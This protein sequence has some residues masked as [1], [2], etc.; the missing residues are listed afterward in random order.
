MKRRNNAKKPNKQQQQPQAQHVGDDA[1]ANAEED[2]AVV[3]DPHDGDGV[4][5][6]GTTTPKGTPDSLRGDHDARSANSPIILPAE[7]DNGDADDVDGEDRD[8]DAGTNK[9]K[10]KS[11]NKKRSV[12]N[13]GS[14]KVVG[15]TIADSEVASSVSP[16]VEVSSSSSLPTS[17]TASSPI[18]A[19][20]NTNTNT[21]ANAN[22]S[23]STTTTTT[24]T[25]CT[26]F[27]KLDS[28]DLLL[29]DVLKPSDVIHVRLENSSKWSCSST[30]G[31]EVKCVEAMTEFVILYGLSPG[32]IKLSWNK[33]WSHFLGFEAHKEDSP[34]FVHDAEFLTASSDLIPIVHSTPSKGELIVSLGSAKF[35]GT[36]ISSTILDR[37][38]LDVTNNIINAAH[39]RLS[40]SVSHFKDLEGANSLYKNMLEWITPTLTTSHIPPESSRLL[41]TLEHLPL[42]RLFLPL[43]HYLGDSIP[44]YLHMERVEQEQLFTQALEFMDLHPGLSFLH[45]GLAQGRIPVIVCAL[46]GGQLNYTAWN[47]D[48]ALEKLIKYH[49]GQISPHYGPQNV[50]VDLQNCFMFEPTSETQFDRVLICGKAPQARFHQMCKLIKPGGLL[51][52]CFETASKAKLVLV[53]KAIDGSISRAALPCPLDL[54]PSSAVV[55]LVAPPM[56]SEVKARF[57]RVKGDF[58]DEEELKQWLL[59]ISDA[60]G[61]ELPDYSTKILAAGFSLSV[62]KEVGLA[63]EDVGCLG[64]PQSHCSALKFA[65]DKYVEFQKALRDDTKVSSQEMIVKPTRV[66]ITFTRV[67]VVESEFDADVDI[68]LTW[69]DEIAWR[70]FAAEK[71]LN[72][73]TS[74]QAEPVHIALSQLHPIPLLGFPNSKGD[75]TLTSEAAYVVPHTGMIEYHVSFSGTFTEIM[76]LQKFPFDRQLLHLNLQHDTRKQ[77]DLRVIWDLKDLLEES[78][79]P[80]NEKENNKILELVS[81]DREWA[82]AEA[83][84]DKEPP[85]A[86]EPREIEQL[87]LVAQAER[88]SSYFMWNIVFMM[89]LIVVMSFLTFTIPA[90]DGSGRLGLNLTLMLTAV[91][92]KYVIAG[93]LPKTTYLTLLDKYVLVGFIVLASVICENSAASV[94]EDSAAPFFDKVAILTLIPLWLLL[95][96]GIVIGCAFD[97]FRQSWA[98][99]EASQETTEPISGPVYKADSTIPPVAVSLIAA[100]AVKKGAR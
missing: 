23:T 82:R 38:V 94:A 45:I 22:A 72:A 35:P 41:H 52:G 80:R 4:V 2:L 47:I 86:E 44:F 81:A 89:F 28:N 20:A 70:E 17:L 88:Y 69:K 57:S 75:V 93:Y 13:K 15:Q 12:G 34:F 99:V 59:Y 90:D 62:I 67:G 83:K 42:S 18:T 60:Y 97:F 9:P 27:T 66:K 16:G 65:M 76:E 40:L 39:F 33:E 71:N 26:S 5:V 87:I 85:T 61:I 84:I 43:R 7:Q 29:D 54:D 63:E 51:V 37:G 30:D 48:N 56:I 46:L 92:Y 32:T 6:V 73:E 74:T 14:K 21:N 79:K 49:I 31:T 100:L 78:V 24:T 64:I 8:K 36:F 11:K 25:S 96:V 10:P 68:V 91:A 19:N 1:K 53:K 55:P 3:V 50:R 98:E 58:S 77:P 95:H